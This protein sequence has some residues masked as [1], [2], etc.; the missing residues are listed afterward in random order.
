MREILFRGKGKKDDVWYHG[1]LQCFKG[2]SIFSTDWK[3]FITVKSETIG[4]FTGLTDK[5]GV[6]IFEG[7]IV[8][9]HRYNYMAVIA[10]HHGCF[11]Y[12]F[13]GYDEDGEY[14]VFNATFD[15]DDC[16]S[17]YGHDIV[18]VIG[19]IHDNPELLEVK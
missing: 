17:H 4:Q 9:I 15:N 1:S 10:F 8:R 11:G 19:N 13:T 7:D 14:S 3:N 5:N 2:Y 6:K 16:S 12:C 18:E